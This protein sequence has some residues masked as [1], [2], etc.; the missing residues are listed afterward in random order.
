MPK[1]KRERKQQWTKE[2]LCFL[3]IFSEYKFHIMP[4]IALPACKTTQYSKRLHRPAPRAPVEFAGFY[5]RG[6]LF[7]EDSFRN[8]SHEEL[9][10]LV[11]IMGVDASKLHL[12]GFGHLLPRGWERSCFTLQENLSR[13]IATQHIGT[14]TVTGGIHEILY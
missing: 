6:K 11:S 1:Q 9:F 12:S 13:S 8:A 7:A 5:L 3:S 4:H 14:R 2:S 10:E